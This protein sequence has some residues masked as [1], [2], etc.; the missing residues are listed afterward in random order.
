[1]G[2]LAPDSR[3]PSTHPA[4][5]PN[6]AYSGSSRISCG[7]AERPA[8]AGANAWR[9]APHPRRCSRSTSESQLTLGVAAPPRATTPGSHDSDPTQAPDSGACIQKP[10]HLKDYVYIFRHTWRGMAALLPSR[11]ATFGWTDLPQH[12]LTP[13][14]TALANRGKLRMDDTQ[15]ETRMALAPI[16]V[17]YEGLCGIGRPGLAPKAALGVCLCAVSADAPLVT[18]PA[19]ARCRL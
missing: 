14:P 7:P 16:A 2:A 13:R 18:T 11:D 19:I 12:R 9:C 10:Q 17:P 8:S 6:P 1:M 3:Q 4:V 15:G 5:W